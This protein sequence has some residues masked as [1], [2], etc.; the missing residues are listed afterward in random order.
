MPTCTATPPPQLPVFHPPRYAPIS[1]PAGTGPNVLGAAAHP[2]HAAAGR[3]A[4]RCARPVR[5]QRAV[6]LYAGSLAQ[7]SATPRASATLSLRSR[8]TGLLAAPRALPRTVRLADPLMTLQS[9]ELHPC[10]RES[11]LSRGHCDRWR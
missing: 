11:T 9:R 3:R 5:G 1:L 6:T 10:I 4:R 8:R 2:R 7:P